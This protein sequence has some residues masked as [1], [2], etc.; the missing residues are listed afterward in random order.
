MLNQLGRKLFSDTCVKAGTEGNAEIIAALL[1]NIF[2]TSEHMKHHH[3]H[4]K[5]AELALKHALDSGKGPKVLQ[6]LREKYG[7]P[8][9]FNYNKV[10]EL[11]F[12]EGDTDSVLELLHGYSI[13]NHK[14]GHDDFPCTI[15]Y[16]VK[17]A[18][19][20][21]AKKGQA[22]VFALVHDFVS[23]VPDPSSSV[24]IDLSPDS[25]VDS[26]CDAI[27]NGHVSVIRELREKWG[28]TRVQLDKALGYPDHYRDTILQG[29]VWHG[30][31]DVL[32]ELWYNWGLTR[33]DFSRNDFSS[34]RVGMNTI[35][36]AAVESRKHEMLEFLRKE[37]GVVNSSLFRRLPDYETSIVLYEI[38]KSD[39]P[40]GMFK[41]LRDG[42]GACMETMQCYKHVYCY[43][44]KRVPIHHEYSSRLDDSQDLKITKAL[45][46]FKEVFGE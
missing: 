18:F 29:A 43:P 23:I 17:C 5:P 19:R 13:L 35:I 3:H 15:D 46:A 9:S 42:W 1:K 27:R 26:L 30:Y 20:E 25:F 16:N 41:E 44:D 39:D 40:L 6:E 45:E 22:N 28:L 11:F 12:G 21:A 33:E 8:K 4:Y 7:I 24:T 38:Y 14:R 2:L 34:R 31:V 37:L 10:I 32:K 36:V